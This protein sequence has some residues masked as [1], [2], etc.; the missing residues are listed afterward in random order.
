LLFQYGSNMAEATLQAKV[1]QYAPEFAPA[2]TPAELTLRGCAR[3][4]G[5]CFSLGLYS[6]G[7]GCRVADIMEATDIDEVWGALYELPSELVQRA[8]GK[9]SVLDRIE[10]HRTTRDP[11]NYVPRAVSVEFDGTSA[12]AWTY[13]G[14]DEARDR[15]SRDHH[16]ARVTVAYADSILR[17]AI[18]VAIPTAHVERLRAILAAYT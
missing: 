12:M 3:L 15:C 8:D 5:W 14:L 16:E 2:G 17:G 7:N 10:G 9:R 6:F 18:A 13:V 11:E 4:Q 1:E